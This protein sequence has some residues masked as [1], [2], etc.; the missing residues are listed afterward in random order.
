MLAINIPADGLFLAIQNKAKNDLSQKNCERIINEYIDN[1]LEAG[2]DIILL[3]VCYRRALTPSQIFDSYL[4]NIETD[5]EGYACRNEFG[6]TLKSF[7]P[8]TQSVSK[9]FLS[10]I[11]CAREL[12][13]K[14]IDV[15]K[16]AIER[17]KK[18]KCR[19]F[20]SVR[21][22]DAHYTDNVAINSNFAIKNGCLHTIGR[23]GVNLDYSQ[24][25]VRNYYYA[26][27]KELLQTYQVDG[28][29][30]DWLRY[31]DIL[32]DEKRSNLDIIS[33]YMKRIH[34]L[35][36]D[37]NENAC[38][39]VRL[40][41]T[42]EENLSKGFDAC[43][44]IADGVAD[45]LTIENFYIPT[46]FEL[47]VSDWKQNIEK[48]NTSG[49][50]YYL[51]CGSDWGVSCVSQYNIAMSPALVRG[52]SETCYR[53]GSDG[54]YLFNFF[55]ENDTSSFEFLLQG[56]NQ[57]ILRNCFLERM[58][59]VK[60]F[61]KLPRRYVHVGNS[62][63]R[64]PIFLRPNESYAFKKKIDNPFEKCKIIIG[65]S[66]ETQLSIYANNCLLNEFQ[67]ETVCGGFEYV[68]ETEIGKNNH[69][70][71]ALTQAAPFVY[72]AYLP[73][74]ILKNNTLS[75]EIKNKFCDNLEILWIEIVCE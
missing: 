38:L 47:P 41:P 57:G 60:D 36:N 49:N 54:I 43:G 10:F 40:L 6:E 59:A 28:I 3:N 62:N 75:V 9:Y 50:P 21:M 29:E 13:Q 72:S 5:N 22:N 17:I 51:F 42:V 30:L 55:E 32:P 27:I 45:M 35:L 70:I 44:W 2:A 39:A 53:N 12:L 61:K 4:Y 26:Y 7:S 8:T 25:A 74:N 34:K 58:K 48:K 31:P 14:Q 37:Y 23:D 1:F 73:N 33:G 11:V 18:T 63:Q 64:Y 65:T 71:Y 69:F 20:L 24:E 56:H 66:K 16:I 67:K 15:Y 52:F 46:N 19:V 68:P